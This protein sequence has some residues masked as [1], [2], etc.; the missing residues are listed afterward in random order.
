[1]DSDV[2]PGTDEDDACAASYEY[3]RCGFRHCGRS[4]TRERRPGRPRL[5]C[6]NECGRAERQLRAQLGTK[7]TRIW[8]PRH[9]LVALQ[10]LLDHA[11]AL[12]EG[13]YCEAGLKELLVRADD[14]RAAVD[15]YVE[16]AVADARARGMSWREVAV[17]ADVHQRTARA[18]WGHQA[19]ER[20]LLCLD[21]QPALPGALAPRQSADRD[22]LAKAVSFLLA[23]TR[24]SPA[25]VAHRTGIAASAVSQLADGQ[26]VPDWTT[27]SAVVTAA[28]GE[29][30]DFRALW[31]WASGCSAGSPLTVTSALARFHGALRGLLWAAEGSVLGRDNEVT[32][33]LVQSVSGDGLVPNWNTTRLIVRSAGAD[34]ERVRPLWLD[35]QRTL[36]GTYKRMRAQGGAHADELS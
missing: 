4:F 21:A 1:M 6:D 5:Y 23:S 31:E 25:G 13:E 11:G 3:T 17:T 22:L 28:G 35:V 16:G 15:R 7:P 10:G 8:A 18:R 36:L 20:S 26:R 34:P 14:V 29:P 24:S 27:V 32:A 9:G 33:T 12:A 30:G 2:E 19:V